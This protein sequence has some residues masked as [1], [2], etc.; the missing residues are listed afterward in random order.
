MLLAR[1]ANNMR[2]KLY[3]CLFLC[4]R[5]VRRAQQNLN[6]ICFYYVPS[7]RD[8]ITVIDAIDLIAVRLNV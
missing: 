3:V 1:I 2:R 6:A 4:A 7:M 5:T 8:I